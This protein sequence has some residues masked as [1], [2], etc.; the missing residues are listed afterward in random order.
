MK[1]CVKAYLDLFGL[2]CEHVKHI[3]D[4]PRQTFVEQC[5]QMDKKK[6]YFLSVYLV[7]S[8]NSTTQAKTASAASASAPPSDTI[9]GASTVLPPMM[10]E[11]EQPIAAEPLITHD[12]TDCCQ[13][14]NVSDMCMG[15]CT[16]HNILDGTTGTEP[17]SC[18]KDFPNIVKC[19]ADGRNHQPCC[20]KANVPDICQVC[21]LRV[22]FVYI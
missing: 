16:V 11:P 7:K 1:E 5:S 15:F 13:L 17:E 6:N 10:F 20:E 19:M 18:E 3:F 9:T 12:F 22:A 14:S 2:L 4:V 21:V 8:L